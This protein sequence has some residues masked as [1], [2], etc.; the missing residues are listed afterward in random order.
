MIRV[1]AITPIRSV[2]L[3]Q[4]TDVRLRTAVRTSG[5][6]S[7]SGR[8]LPATREHMRSYRLP[9]RGRHPKI[10]QCKVVIRV[11]VYGLERLCSCKGG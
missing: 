7:M 6:S 2:S 5:L 8:P 3:F 1:S 11:E 9:I 10:Q 4:N